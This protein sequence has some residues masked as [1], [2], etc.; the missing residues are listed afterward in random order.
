MSEVAT[1]PERGLDENP[2]LIP[3][4]RQQL[5]AR[6][7][8][9]NLLAGLVVGMVVV[10]VAL[11]FAALVFSGDLARFVPNGIGLALYTAVVVGL[12]VALSSSFPGM[13]A[14]PQDSPATELSRARSSAASRRASSSPCHIEP[15]PGTKLI[16]RK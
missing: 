1:R 11:S 8:P 9:L 5:G 2:R 13:V 3:H 7:L 15:Y 6:H 14:T 12:V 16:G 4:L 10:I